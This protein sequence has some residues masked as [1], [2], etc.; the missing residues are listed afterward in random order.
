MRNLLILLSIL[1][2]IVISSVSFEDAFATQSDHNIKPT[3]IFAE[4]AYESN[5]SIPAD[6]ISLEFYSTI[7]EYEWNITNADTNQ[8]YFNS[9]SLTPE[10][11][12]PSNE[13]PAGNYTISCT[14][15]FNDNHA[16]TSDVKSFSVIADSP[17][18]IVYQSPT[19]T[20]D[21]RDYNQDETLEATCINNDSSNVKKYQWVISDVTKKKKVNHTNEKTQLSTFSISG[22]E[23]T[24]GNNYKIKCNVIFPDSSKVYGDWIDFS[25]VVTPPDSPPD[26]IDITNDLDMIYNPDSKNLTISWNFGDNPHRDSCNSKTE[27]RQGNYVSLNPLTYAIGGSFFSFEGYN[28]DTF[29][30]GGLVLENTDLT[31]SEI[32]CADEMVFNIE[33]TQVSNFTDWFALYMT[34]FEVI[35]PDYRGEPQYDNISPNGIIPLNEA[36][37]VT[38]MKI[39]IESLTCE[40]IGSIYDEWRFVELIHD[41]TGFTKTVYKSVDGCSI[42][43]SSSLPYLMKEIADTHSKKKKGG[44]DIGTP[45]STFGKDKN[46]NQIVTDGFCFNGVCVDVDKLHTEFPLVIAPVGKTS[47]ITVKVY[48]PN[49]LHEI[50]TIQV[51]L[52][53]KEAGQPL[54]YGE[55][56]NTF[57]I[58]QSEIEKTIT[59]DKNNLIKETTITIDTVRC[60]DE[61]S[62]SNCLEL[63][64][65]FIPQDQ[66]INNVVGI[67]A[68]NIQ[69]AGS[70]NYINHGI[71]FHG[72]S[73]NEPLLSTVSSGIGGAFY[74]QERGLVELSL[75]NYSESLWQDEYGYLWKINDYGF[76]IIDD[77]PVPLREPDVMWS[78]MTR[79]NSNFADM[80]IHE[81]NKA[82]LI[83]DSTK[84]ISIPGESFAY[85][86][87]KSTVEQQAELDIRI[88][89]E[90]DR[91]EKQLQ[92]LFN[93][94]YPSKV[95]D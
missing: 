36:Q 77:I 60:S 38:S 69:R 56:I 23:F 5:R 27:I 54:S 76:Y 78:A 3:L 86:L 63:S 82:I 1:S 62:T 68:Y 14:V 43:D 30:D 49:S 51:I 92:E 64:F 29:G 71:E 6:C 22:T 89:I 95:H 20:F 50:K 37:F 33:S 24:V 7:K 94:I 15:I 67:N 66:L 35:A 41:I 25:I 42:D 81:Q 53:L 13:F 12:K 79:V 16:I 40:E 83:F 48:N 9:N 59:V 47:N 34:F 31:N 85:D 52:G 93:H 65:D 72:I 57:H 26:S 84:L 28:K 61:Y 73:L 74:P 75:I 4:I 87:P 88:T 80:I 18:P 21:E 10:F 90:A 2:V 91:A 45:P 58:S 55:V 70:T 8:L 11:S 44:G 46:Y 32:Q 17:D 19:L 39:D